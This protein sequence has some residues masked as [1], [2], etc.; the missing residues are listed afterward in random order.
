MEWADPAA[1]SVTLTPL[2]LGIIV[3]SNTL[4]DTPIPNAPD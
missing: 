2:K 1:I 4:F 3:G